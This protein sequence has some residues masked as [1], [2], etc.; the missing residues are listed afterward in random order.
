MQLS[1]YSI[2]P[3]IVIL[4]MATFSK[5]IIPSIIAGCIIACLLTTDFDIFEAAKLL[6][7]RSHISAGTLMLFGF[8]FFVGII[9]ALINA[10]GGATAFANLITKR[11]R[12]A[13]QVEST[14]FLMAFI[15]FI[16]D[17][18]STVTMG[19]VLQ[20]LTDKFRI[21]RAKLAFLIHSLG[22]PV[23]V[24]APISSWIAI[25]TNQLEAAG[26]SNN[27]IFAPKFLADQFFVFLKTIPFL[28]YSILIITSAWIIVR[29]KLSFGPM[30]KQEIIASETGN[31][32][33][34]KSPHK[35]AHHETQKK[36]SIWDLFIPII[37]LVAGVF[38]GIPY[39]GGFWL[40]GGNNSLVQAF[41]KCPDIGPI[42]FTSSLIALILGLIF[43]LWQKKVH[44][45][46]WPSLIKEGYNLMFSAILIVFT[47]GI[48]GSILKNDLHTGQYLSYLL[49]PIL[50]ISFLPATLFLVSFL[51]SLSIGT[52]W[53]T[54]AILIPIA[55]QM[56][57]Q[58]MGI[59]GA[60]DLNQAI[61]L[62]PTL[63]AVLSGAIAGNQISPIS[64]TTF[65]TVACTGVYRN[66]HINTQLWYALPAII[67]A[68]LGFLIMPSVLIYSFWKGMLLTTGFSI[69]L[70]VITLFIL[71]RF[72]KNYK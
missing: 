29:F 54:L 3:P 15:L 48:L 9:I 57:S 68:F 52:A 12:S 28:L 25:I 13:R 56:L 20:P 45:Y 65:L 42:L 16:D 6:F 39:T 36:S 69:G 66:D 22:S 51:I 71:N 67:F 53:G 64:D 55:I 60:I 2:I 34:G 1:W 33:G 32:F 72:F 43:G 18:L 37:T 7:V 10:T 47:A 5:K 11:I 38:I 30:A 27:P 24:M 40:F 46:S 58:M 19:Y 50:N 49:E 59:T 31:V 21:P 62:C 70:C 26:V 17:Y 4:L 23:V 63:G 14:S 61:L 8:V 41:T 44:F 35:I